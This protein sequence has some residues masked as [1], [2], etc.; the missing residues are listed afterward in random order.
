MDIVNPNYLNYMEQIQKNRKDIEK[1]YDQELSDISQLNFKENELNGLE[2]ENGKATFFGKSTIIRDENTENLEVDSQ[3]EL[4]ISSGDDDI[5]IDAGEDNSTLEIHLDNTTRNKINR[6]LLTPLNT[7]LEDELVAVGTNNAQKMIPLTNLTGKVLWENFDEI[8]AGYTFT[9]QTITL[10]SNDYD[11]FEMIF[12]M[13]S[14][15]KRT[16]SVKYLKGEYGFAM[17]CAN[18]SSNGATAYTR[19]CNVTDNYS[20]VFFEHGYEAKGSLAEYILDT[21]SIPLKIIGYKR[22]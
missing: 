15:N 1:L 16:L 2:Y 8:I 9:E 5:V 7:P 4:K 10:N 12:Y 11:E 21:V 22:G 20:K 18:A 3:V 19:N 13:S 17:C 6:S 14:S